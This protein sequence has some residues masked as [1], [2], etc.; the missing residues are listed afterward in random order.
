MCTD[1]IHSMGLFLSLFL[2]F[3]HWNKVFFKEN[4]NKKEQQNW[5]KKDGK[6]D[7]LQFILENVIK[8]FVCSTSTSK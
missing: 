1:A 8:E 7:V 6:F 4:K 2:S 3:L 5:R